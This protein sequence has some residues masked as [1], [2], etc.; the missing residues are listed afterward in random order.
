MAAKKPRKFAYSVPRNSPAL[1][2]IPGRLE[3]FQ[4]AAPQHS[5]ANQPP[6]QEAHA[7]PP[8]SS[9][10]RLGRPGGN[11]PPV[12]FALSGTGSGGCSPRCVGPA[13][14]RSPLAA[15][16][17]LL[18]PPVNFF[19]APPLMHRRLNCHPAA[20]GSF[21][22]ARCFYTPRQDA[23]RTYSRTGV[24]WTGPPWDAGFDRDNRKLIPRCADRGVSGTAAAW[25]AFG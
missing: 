24:R 25:R 11:V 1:Q 20:S 18:S 6:E 16:Q 22:N 8:V 13:T 10:P 3:R 9:P 2:N 15:S 7:R 5:A 21:G 19:P 23:L 17:T 14:R 12:C 4:L